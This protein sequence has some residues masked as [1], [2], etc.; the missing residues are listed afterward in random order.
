MEQQRFDKGK[1]KNK[2]LRNNLKIKLSE[3]CVPWM[4][5][6]QGTLLKCIYEETKEK[7]IKKYSFLKKHNKTTNSISS[8]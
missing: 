8:K 7:K 4:E 3:I 1:R 6:D 2:A 5:L